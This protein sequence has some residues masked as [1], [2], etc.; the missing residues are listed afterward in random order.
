M[1]SKGK[2]TVRSLLMHILRFCCF[3]N[4][5]RSLHKR[6][7]LEL[8]Q[9]SSAAI[10]MSQPNVCAGPL[11]FTI[12]L[13]ACICSFVR[14]HSVAGTT[15]LEIASTLSPLSSQSICGM[16]NPYREINSKE[17][18]LMRLILVILKFLHFIHCPASN[19]NVDM[20]RIMYFTRNILYLYIRFRYEML[21]TSQH[22]QL[23]RGHSALCSYW[24]I[25]PGG[26]EKV[27]IILKSWEKYI[28]SAEQMSKIRNNKV[29]SFY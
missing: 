25:V 24:M 9:N 27:E 11:G 5:S 1:C 10:Y 17:F 29:S 16:I 4:N 28:V 7:W 8:F 13:S 2:T 6:N 23:V 15:I 22:P 26:A 14:E 12:S 20:Q 19:L 21:D 3:I 18:Y